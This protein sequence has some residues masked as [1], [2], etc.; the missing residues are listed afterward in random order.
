MLKISKILVATTLL[1][2]VVAG[3]TGCGEDRSNLLPSDTATEIEVSL[4]GIQKLAR[5]DCFRALQATRKVQKQVEGLPQSVDPKLKRT[6]L[7]GVVA[8][9][10]LLGDA[11]KCTATGTTTEPTEPEPETEVSPTGDTGVTTPEE[12]TPDGEK[13][14]GK[15]NSEKKPETPTPTPD[16]TPEPTPTPTPEP[17][18]D[19]NPPVDPGS[20]SGGVSPNQ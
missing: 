20:G 6:L 4:T 15:K 16:P 8:L 3:F 7:D 2:F 18:P 12:T 14:P 13:D 10:V 17:P 9:Q 5:T 1:T 11:D 19:A